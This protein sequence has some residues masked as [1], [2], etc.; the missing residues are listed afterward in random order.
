M[1]LSGR[2]GVLQRSRRSE[3]R[4]GHGG[5]GQEKRTGCRMR[6]RRSKEAA[7]R[8]IMLELEAGEYCQMLV[9]VL[10]HRIS[11]ARLF[12]HECRARFRF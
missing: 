9:C 5:I 1:L 11:A 7:A 3:R 10:A 4:G 2:L 6:C 12:M 8:A